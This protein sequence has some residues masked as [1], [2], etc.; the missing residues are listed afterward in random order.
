MHPQDWFAFM[1][2]QTRPKSVYKQLKCLIGLHKFD[3][4]VY[5]YHLQAPYQQTY[6]GR[7]CQN[8][9]LIQL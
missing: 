3:T 1:H 5:L 6:I 9:C 2:L 4:C 8:C 7:Q